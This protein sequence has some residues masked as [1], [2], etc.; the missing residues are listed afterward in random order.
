MCYFKLCFGVP[1]PGCGLTRA[2]CCLAH[3]E[4]WRAMQFNFLAP[5]LLAWLT[6]WWALSVARLRRPVE[7]PR[8]FRG[9]GRWVMVSFLVFY[10]GRM[11]VYFSAPEGYTSFA[12]QNALGRI[13]RLDLSN[14]YEPG[15]R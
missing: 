15:A 3:L 7:D 12:T 1:C 2:F 5:M 6:A 9:F 11:V 10:A 8:W 4:I 14:T 13:V